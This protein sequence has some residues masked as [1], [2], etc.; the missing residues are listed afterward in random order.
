MLKYKLKDNPISSFSFDFLA[1]YL[2][3]LGIE[4]P[5]SFIRG[6]EKEDEED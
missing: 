4:K 6:P 3:T 2:R 1:D 5:N